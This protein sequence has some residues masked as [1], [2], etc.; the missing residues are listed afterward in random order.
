MIRR[1]NADAIV[2]AFE[3]AGG[4]NRCR[5][6]SWLMLCVSEFF[7]RD[8]GESRCMSK[9]EDQC[10]NIVSQR[11]MISLTYHIQ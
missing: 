11:Q 4:S 6:M 9:K 8:V 5:W 7:A 3:E 2:L 1:A 10:L